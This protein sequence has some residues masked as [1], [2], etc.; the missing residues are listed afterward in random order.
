MLSSV[1]DR[2]MTFGSFRGRE[3]QAG[4]SQIPPGEGS[5]RF[6]KKVHRQ[7]SLGHIKS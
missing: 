5:L 6:L 3:V 4:F 7:S 1:L 2:R